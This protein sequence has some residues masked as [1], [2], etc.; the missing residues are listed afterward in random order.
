[1]PK[2]K[3]K[4]HSPKLESILMVE[5]AIKKYSSQYTIYQLWKKIPKKMMY[6]TYKII[7]EYLEESSKIII[8]KD[9]IVIWIYDKK[10]IS[11]ILSLGV[12]LR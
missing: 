10:N 1:M 7:L 6:Q 3:I 9:N 11:K 8:D 2:E 4:Y 12:K 5:N